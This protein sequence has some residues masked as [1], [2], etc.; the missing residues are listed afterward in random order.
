M[1][2][3]APTGSYLERLK[4]EARKYLITNWAS[5]E[6]VATALLRNNTLSRVEIVDLFERS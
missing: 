3:S 4:I 6:A 1:P 2:A 5:V